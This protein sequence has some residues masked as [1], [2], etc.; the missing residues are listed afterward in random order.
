MAGAS[1]PRSISPGRPPIKGKRPGG[2]VSGA[3]PEGPP[4]PGLLA[5][6]RA[7][8]PALRAVRAKVLEADPEDWDSYARAFDGALT[9]IGPVEAAGDAVAES[10]AEEPGTGG[11]R[12]RAA[13]PGPL[14]GTP[15]PDGQPGERLAI[16][17]A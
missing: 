8:L 10:R 16:R 3:G 15:L 17:D 7:A 12:S 13:P 1:P 6:A 4:S 9:A 5:L 2:A 11:R 14:P